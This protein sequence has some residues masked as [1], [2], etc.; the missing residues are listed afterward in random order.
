[1]LIL[2]NPSEIFPRLLLRCCVQLEI[3]E[4][5]RDQAG[6]LLNSLGTSHAARESM[7]LTQKTEWMTDGSSDK[8]EKIVP[9]T[10]MI[11]SIA[12]M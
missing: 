2:L 7:A 5:E 11:D 8:Q 4:V 3:R 9:I 6:S 1:M 12:T 10:D